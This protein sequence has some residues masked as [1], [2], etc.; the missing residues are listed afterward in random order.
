[1][2]GWRWAAVLVAVTLVAHGQLDVDA[3]GAA[4]LV[5]AGPYVASFNAET[6]MLSR[7]CLSDGT[8]MITASRIYHD[9]FMDYPRESFTSTAT[10]PMVCRREADTVIVEGE[11]RLVN[12]AGR[13]HAHGA[14][15]YLVRY[16]F[17]DSADIHVATE[18]RPRFTEPALKGFLAHILTT[19][20]QR[21]FFVH[22]P[23]GLICEVAATRSMRTWQAVNEPLDPA[24]ARFGVLLTVGPTLS[25][26]VVRQEPVPQNTFFHDSGNGPTTVFFAWLA[27]TGTRTITDGDVWRHEFTIARGP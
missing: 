22:T 15:D 18:I 2:H 4:P 8:E 20:P 3:S 13:P 21:E 1:M 17:A 10:A 6:G 19:A 27:G 25:F 11:G 16:T 23:D 24:L 14:F 7:L 26:R 5:R 9:V 12:A